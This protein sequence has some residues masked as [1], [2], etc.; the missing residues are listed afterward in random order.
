VPKARPDGDGEPHLRFAGQGGG[1]VERQLEGIFA[2]MDDRLEGCAFDGHTERQRAGAQL[3][4][5]AISAQVEFL[6]VGGGSTQAQ[7]CAAAG[8]PAR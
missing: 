8:V 7:R 1:K 2:G 6:A 5:R 4:V 3:F